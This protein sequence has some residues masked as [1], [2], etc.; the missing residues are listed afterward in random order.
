MTTPPAS[1]RSIGGVIDD[2]IQLAR[3]GFGRC[4][5]LA[6][7]GSLAA[8]L[9]GLW[10]QMKLAA[11]GAG[12]ERTLA[13][14]SS[15]A[16]SISTLLQAVLWTLLELALVRVLLALAAGRPVGSAWGELG[17]ALGRLPGALL[18]GFV[19]IVGV[20]VGLILFIVP[21]LWLA[22]RWMLFIPAYAD[23]RRGVFEALGVSFER[24][25][26]HWWRSFTIIT[27][28][29]L[30]AMVLIMAPALL[31]GFVAGVLRFDRAA[32]LIGTSLVGALMQTIYM[33]LFCAA[34]VAIDR[35]LAVRREGSDLEARLGELDG[36]RV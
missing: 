10:P 21:G 31:F 19:A 27:V 18:G 16:Y 7:A 24:V 11:A 9:L 30:I 28:V 32:A 8:L 5:S 36:A 15:P 33:P 17:G 13:V 26:G 14:M 29:G 1:P 25:G 35:D 12:P 34:L 4:W 20:V 23:G 22:I 3:H 2:A 6:L